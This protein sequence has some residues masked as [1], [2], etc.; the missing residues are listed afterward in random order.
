MGR[1]LGGDDVKSLAAKG[2]AEFFKLTSGDK[3]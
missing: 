2:A 3:K 1:V